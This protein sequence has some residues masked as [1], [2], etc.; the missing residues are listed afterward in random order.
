MVEKTG[1]DPT[2]TARTLWLETHPL[3]TISD[4]TRIEGPTSVASTSDLSNARHGGG[5]AD[6]A[7]M[8]KQSRLRKRPSLNDVV[9][10]TGSQPAQCAQEH[11]SDYAGRQTALP[12]Q[13]RPVMGS[14]PVIGALED[15]EDYRAFEAVVIA[16]YDALS[17]VERELV[18]RLASLLWRLRR[19]TIME[20]GLFEIQ[21]KHLKEFRQARQALPASREVIYTL[22]GRVDS[23]SHNR[24]PASREIANTTEAIPSSEAK[25]YRTCR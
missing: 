1:I 6:S 9:Q 10:A 4:Q 22:L 20:T 8:T 19:A 21:A 5:P 7:Q 11:R 17:A 3:P 2:L 14:P 13:R 18:L 12:L 25:S 15:A 23:V 16:D 24:N